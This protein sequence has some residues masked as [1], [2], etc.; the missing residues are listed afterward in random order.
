MD[1][2]TKCNSFNLRLNSEL[3]DPDSSRGSHSG[4]NHRKESNNVC[5]SQHGNEDSETLSS[6]ISSGRD[7][8][9]TP[10]PL[11]YRQDALP[12]SVAAKNAE[13]DYLPTNSFNSNGIGEEKTESKL[14]DRL[15]RKERQRSI[16]SFRTPNLSGRSFLAT[17]LLLT[18][19]Y[20]SLYLLFTKFILS[21]QRV[22]QIFNRVFT[23]SETSNIKN[24]LR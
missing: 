5:S 12:S 10:R 9:E 18:I 20:I 6:P 17:L 22:A 4:D 24:L 2:T 14:T 13:T 1:D 8:S 15:S 19:D 7:L 3:H 21:N 11:L 23:F 16:S